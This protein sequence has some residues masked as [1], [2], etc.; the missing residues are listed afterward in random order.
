MTRYE[1][2]L[3]A[4]AHSALLGLGGLLTLAGQF[5]CRGSQD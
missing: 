5:A 4:F 3:R 1:P 2:R